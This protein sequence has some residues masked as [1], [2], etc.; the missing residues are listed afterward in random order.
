MKGWK[1]ATWI[2]LVIAVLTACG[3]KPEE[4]E[5][6]LPEEAEQPGEQFSEE[7]ISGEEELGEDILLHAVDTELG[8]GVFGRLELYGKAVNEFEW[9]G[10][11]W[12]VRYMTWTPDGAE[13]P[14]CTV[15][16]RDA[17]EEVWA[18][19]DMD[20]E[21]L[22]YTEAWNQDGGLRLEDL[23]F[24]GYLDISL[25]AWITASNLAYYHWL[26]DPGTE[27]FAYGFSTNMLDTI[28]TEKQLLVCTPHSGATN[29]TLYYGYNEN[30]ELYLAHQNTMEYG[31]PITS[32]NEYHGGAVTQLTEAELAEFAAYFHQ[33]ERIDLLRDEGQE[34]IDIPFYEFTDGCRFLDGSI[35][36]YYHIAGVMSPEWNWPMHVLLT[37]DGEGGWRILRIHPDGS[38]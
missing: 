12:G 26:Y 20:S 15:Y 9:G 19:L 24:D 8:E 33:K 1:W 37:D 32:T 5:S 29:E 7:E 3:K 21:W 14:V 6:P 36:L 23:N 28:D 27:Q 2:F 16:A 17:N 38:Y 30:G 4:P 34:D 11:N 25:Q 31:N 13:E 18:G 22:E 35:L 10:Y